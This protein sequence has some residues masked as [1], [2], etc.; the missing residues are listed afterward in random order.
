MLP[1]QIMDGISKKAQEVWFMSRKLSTVGIV[2]LG[3][4]LIGGSLVC[5]AQDRQR[6]AGGDPGQM[7]QM[8]MQQMKERLGATDDEW[9]VMEP[10]I[11]KVWDL[12]RESRAGGMG[13]G[14][15]RP[16]GGPGGEGREGRPGGEGR[17]GRSG[18]NRPAVQG[19]D[20]EGDPGRD[21]PVGFRAEESAESK[22]LQEVLDSSTATPE[23]IQA[24]LTAFREARKKKEA[25]LQAAREEL[26]KVLT[27]R[28]EA[29]L[30]L[31]GTLD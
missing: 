19:A 3:L 15:F 10:L 28:Q 22:A 2:T 26:R 30:V 17:Q 9:T 18:E 12:Q 13:P 20:R 24:K 6:R 21:R 7:R 5:M 23:E 29:I 25:E 31:L 8:V 27:V 1:N 11:I 16:S 4:L 14:F